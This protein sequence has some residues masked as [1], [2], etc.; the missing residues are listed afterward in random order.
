MKQKDLTD[1]K[2]KSQAELATIV[3]K[4]RADIVKA[5]MDLEMHHAKNT[6]IVKNLRRNLAQMLSIRKDLK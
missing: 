5:E 2:N 4:T 6:N 3:A 1:L